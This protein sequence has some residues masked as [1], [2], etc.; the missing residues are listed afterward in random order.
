MHAKLVEKAIARSR[1]RYSMILWEAFWASQT[2]P[3]GLKGQS[4]TAG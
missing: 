2:L 3:E 4:L 1:V